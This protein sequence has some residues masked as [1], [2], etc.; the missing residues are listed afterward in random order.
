MAIYS[1]RN[2]HP[3][4]IYLP[5][6]GGV[7]SFICDSQIDEKTMNR[8][9]QQEYKHRAN[10]LKALANPTR[11]FVID[12]LAK[13]GELCVCELTEKVGTDMSTVSRHLA[14]LREVGI[15]E[16]EKRGLNVYYRLCFPCLA[17]VFNCIEGNCGATSELGLRQESV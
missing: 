4:R 2:S 8:K 14:R 11:L 1:G 5:P 6:K 16:D 3:W 7:G 17:D 12:E 13:H 15:I 9:I 10:I